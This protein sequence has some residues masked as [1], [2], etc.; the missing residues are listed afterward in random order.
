M[1]RLLPLFASLVA[2]LLFAK[3]AGAAAACLPRL[4]GPAMVVC[5]AGESTGAPTP[6]QPDQ[7]AGLG[8]PLC[9][10]LP[11]AILAA[12]PHIMPGRMVS[13]PAAAAP[14]PRWV[15]PGTTRPTPLHARAPP[16]LS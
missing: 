2:V 7:V 13:L 9:A 12:P 6:N 14:L 1:R 8:C 15:A 3:W 10:P 11:P 4:R 5:H 16:A